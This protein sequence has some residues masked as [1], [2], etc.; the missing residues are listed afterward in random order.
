MDN[1]EN[2]ITQQYLKK[3]RKQSQVPLASDKVY[4]CRRGQVWDHQELTIPSLT[5]LTHKTGETKRTLGLAFGYQAVYI[6]HLT[7]SLDSKLKAW[8][9]LVD[10]NLMQRVTSEQTFP[11]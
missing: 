3:T 2:L 4:S 10:H 1:N 8:I 11:T 7:E 6:P 9:V 5:Q